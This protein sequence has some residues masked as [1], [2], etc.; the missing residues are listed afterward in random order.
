MVTLNNVDYENDVL[1][2]NKI[3]KRVRDD[4]KKICNEKKLN[5]GRLV[6]EFYKSIILRFSDGTLNASN[7]YITMNIFREP[8]TIKYMKSRSLKSSNRDVPGTILRGPV[9]K[10]KR[11][12]TIVV[13]P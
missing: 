9:G 5:K 10:R 13:L 6:E 2:S 1:D 8:I 7:G 3:S 12:N 4:I 11:N